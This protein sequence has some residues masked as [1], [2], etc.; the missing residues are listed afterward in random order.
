[1][2]SLNIRPSSTHMYRLTHTLISGNFHHILAYFTR[3]FCCLPRVLWRINFQCSCNLF[4]WLRNKCECW[5]YIVI[6]YRHPWEIATATDG[7][8]TSNPG[9]AEQHCSVNLKQKCRS[10]FRMLLN[11][12]RKPVLYWM[13]ELG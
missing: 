10:Q 7:V 2:A 11:G 4:K 3:S 8:A 6:P 9:I 1:M 5:E 12:I 13:K